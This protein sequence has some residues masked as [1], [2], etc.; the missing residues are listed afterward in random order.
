MKPEDKQLLIHLLQQQNDKNVVG[1]CGDGANDCGAL[2]QAH[3][4][5]KDI[6]KIYN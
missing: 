4:K 5:Y 1:L 2:K 3:G 6:N